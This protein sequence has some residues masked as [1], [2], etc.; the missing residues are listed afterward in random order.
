MAIAKCQWH[1]ALG[2]FKP[3]HSDL[4][5][6]PFDRDVAI[7]RIGIGPKDADGGE[8]KGNDGKCYEFAQHL[9]NHANK[10]NRGLPAA[11]EITDR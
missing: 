9:H 10:V 5:G 6:C 1:A 11:G 7:V 3:F 8:D 2:S 4:R